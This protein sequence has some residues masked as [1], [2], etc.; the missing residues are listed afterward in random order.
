MPWATEASMVPTKNVILQMRWDNPPEPPTY[1]NFDRK[2][3]LRQ[4]ND[5]HENRRIYGSSNLF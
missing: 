2:G 1:V 5:L 4:E 3:F